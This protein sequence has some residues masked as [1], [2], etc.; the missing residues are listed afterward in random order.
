VLPTAGAVTTQLAI[1]NAAALV[2]ATFHEQVVALELGAGGI[3]AA[4]SS[5]LLTVTLGRF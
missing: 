2:G 3:P 5:S 1:P 4:T